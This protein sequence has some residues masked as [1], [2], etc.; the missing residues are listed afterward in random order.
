MRRCS[1]R[2]PTSWPKKAW[3][4]PTPKNTAPFAIASATALSPLWMPSKQKIST[5][6]PKPRALSPRP[7]P[8]AT[9]TTARDTLPN[10]DPALL[11]KVIAMFRNL[12][13][14]GLL[15]SLTCVLAG[16][17]DDG[18]KPLFDGKSLAGWKQHGGAAKYRIE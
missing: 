15:L 17:D 8:N 16:A 10:L 6:P 1:L 3:P 14:L 11:P 4:T 13:P 9:R 18:F 7:A 12:A 5:K 2:S